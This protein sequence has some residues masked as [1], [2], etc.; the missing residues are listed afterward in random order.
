[1]SIC[2]QFAPYTLRGTDWNATGPAFGGHGHRHA[3]ASTPPI[4]RASILARQVVT[5][6]DLESVNGLT[7]G[8]IFH[9]ELSLDQLFTMRPLVGWA[10]YRTP[11]ERLYL[12]GAGTHPGYGVSGLS[13][14]NAGRGDPQGP[15]VASV[16]QVKH[17]AD[18]D[19]E[20]S[21]GIAGHEDGIVDELRVGVDDEEAC[22]GLLQP[23]EAEI[24]R[25]DIGAVVVLNE[26]LHEHAR[27]E[28]VR[29][30]RPPRLVTN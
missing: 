5:P 9:G 27:R 8:H 15:A 18:F 14:L 13:G 6:R 30:P 29:N 4:S 10:R 11:I 25:P 12:C 20:A 28:R 21:I 24:A 17:P 26:T 3:D 23:S 22:V 19:D 2:A 16:Q 1:M 7:G